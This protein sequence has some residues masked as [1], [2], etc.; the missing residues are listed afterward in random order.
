MELAIARLDDRI[1]QAQKFLE[2]DEFIKSNEF[3]SFLYKIK[4]SELVLKMK[5]DESNEQRM[6]LIENLQAY[7]PKSEVTTLEEARDLVQRSGMLLVPG[8]D[9]E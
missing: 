8:W 6:E 1:I 7:D 9:L 3:K 2:D 4:Q 5:L